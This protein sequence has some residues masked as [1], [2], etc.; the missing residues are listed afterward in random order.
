M[1][2][3]DKGARFGVPGLSEFIEELPILAQGIVLT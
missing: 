2:S 3:G 1:G